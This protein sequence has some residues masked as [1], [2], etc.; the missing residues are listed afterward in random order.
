MK[1]TQE[2]DCGINHPTIKDAIRHAEENLGFRGLHVEPYWGTTR[3]NC[4]LVVGYQSGARKRWRLDFSGQPE[5]GQPPK[6][7]HI[8]EENFE[9]PPGPRYDLPEKVREEIEFYRK[10]RR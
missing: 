5:D 6:F 8:N 4:H 9:A 10:S 1:V 3:W 7:I 2:K